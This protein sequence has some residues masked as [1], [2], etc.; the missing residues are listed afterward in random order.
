MTKIIAAAFLGA[1]VCISRTAAGES[2]ETLVKR[3]GSENFKEREAAHKALL[4]RPTAAAA[5]REAARSTDTE[6]ARRAAEI[7]DFYDR[8]PSRDVEQAVAD[9]QIERVIGLLANLPHD[10]FESEITEIILR[11]PGKV[12]EIHRRRKDGVHAVGWIRT[13]FFGQGQTGQRVDADAGASPAPCRG[14]G[15]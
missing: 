10:K 5:L 6:V 1:A 15:R 7:L 12:A 4:G 11:L 9:G 13:A 2:I 8:K 3:L 14:R